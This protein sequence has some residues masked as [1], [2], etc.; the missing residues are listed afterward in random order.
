MKILALALLL[1]A[2]PVL[3]ETMD[4]G[5]MPPMKM[6]PMPAVYKGQADKPGAPVFTGLGDLHHPISTKNPQTQKFFDQGIDLIIGFNHAEAIR[7]FREAARLDPD[8][9]MCWWGVAFSLG[10]N[11]NL[12][13]PKDAVAPAWAALKMAQSLEAHASPEEREW[14]DALATR[15]SETPPADRSA[16]DE[17]FAQ[18]MGKV[19]KAHPDDLDAGVFYAE[20]LMDTQPWDYWQADYKTPKGHGAEIVATLESIIARAPNHPG[21]L[22]LYIHAVEASTTPERAEAAA[23]RLEVLMPEAGHVVHMPSHIYYRVGRYADAAHVNALAAKT[24]EDYIAACKAQGYYPIG[25]YGHNIH[26]LWTSSEMEGN[27]KASIDAAERLVKATDAYNAAATS[28]FTEFY[29]FTPIATDLRFGKWKAVL[30]RPLPPHT[31]KLDTMV[32][33]YARGFAH[34]N[35]GNLKAARHDR[36]ELAAFYGPADFASY[37]EAPVKDMGQMTLDL[38]DGEIA[39]KSGHLTDAIAHFTRARDIEITLPYTEPPYWHQPVSHLLG[40]ALLQA[41]RPADAEAVYRDSLTRYRMDG[42]ALFG[43]AQALTAQ[44]KKDEA[45]AARKQFATAW[46]LA[47]VKLSSSRF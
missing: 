14:I 41:H 31:L 6:P 32:A 37:H 29:G 19:W 30:A 45:A 1:V 10:P 11:I 12:P 43:L 39:R 25:Y 3:A 22:H 28:P 21:A 42:W 34:A 17:N 8:C 18:A 24:D 23:D 40:A 20:A 2:A 38:L 33:L 7:S 47:D 15:Y 5:A 16:L 35:T 4:M 46:Q 27:Y 44:G 36:A 9:A 26:F 13:M